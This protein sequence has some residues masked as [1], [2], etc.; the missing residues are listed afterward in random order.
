M[1]SENAMSVTLDRQVK[2]NPA[3]FH[4]A[5]NAP[6][7]YRIKFR[8]E[9][10]YHA[11]RK[12]I[13]DFQNG[14]IIYVRR[15]RD[16]GEIRFPKDV[17]STFFSAGHFP[18]FPKEIQDELSAPFERFFLA[19]GPEILGQLRKLYWYRPGRCMFRLEALDAHNKVLVAKQ[20]LVDIPNDSDFL[21]EGAV[22]TI[23]HYVAGLPYNRYATLFLPYGHL[24]H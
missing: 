12:L 19:H 22:S 14:W 21:L 18:Q 15:C 11:V 1:Q 6:F 8:N 13:S 23:L 20:W 2:S 3:A 9:E 7:P 4:V 24:V 5:P 16:D 17:W 10:R